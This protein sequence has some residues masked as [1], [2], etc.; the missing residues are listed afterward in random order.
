[1]DN[2]D[3]N[4]RF[5]DRSQQAQNRGKRSDNTSGYKC[6]YLNKETGRWRVVIAVNRKRRHIGY[7][8]TKE[9]AYAAYLEAVEE[10]HG[11][12]ACVG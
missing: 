6:V 5:A 11:D 3:E 4:L 7:F 1:L 8:S 2:T 12:F 10:I 9:E